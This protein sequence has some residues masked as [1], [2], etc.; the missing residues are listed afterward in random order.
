[1]RKIAQKF[2][3]LIPV[4]TFAVIMVFMAGC[5]KKTEKNKAIALRVF[6]EV[7]N[8]GNLDVIDEIYA[9]DYVGHMPGSPDLQG[10]EG[11]KQF[12]TMQLTAFPDNQFT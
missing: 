12:V 5:A 1:M 2:S 4:I 11:F 3:F 7:W 8:Q 9:I 10:T 6:E